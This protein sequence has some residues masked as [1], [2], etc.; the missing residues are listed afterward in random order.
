MAGPWQP[1]PSLAARRMFLLLVLLGFGLRMGYGLIRYRSAL[2]GSGSEFIG[3]WDHDALY[4]VLIAKAVLAGKGYVVDDSPIT[5]ERHLRYAGQDAL[6]KAPLYQY[7]LAGVFAVSGFSFKLFFPLQALLGGFSTGLTALI[8]LHVFGR[9]RAAWL[10]GG[11]AAVQPILVNSASQPYNENLFFFFFLASIWAFLVWLRSERIPWA[12]L[13]GLM[14]G[15]C[16]LTRESGE[17]LLVAMG[18]VVLVARPVTLRRCLGYGVV[19]A[20]TLAVV[21]PWTVRNYVRT[22]A[23]VP[24][25]SIVGV[26]FTEGNNECIAS[27]S[28]F[29]P[30]WSEGPC[31]LVD[32]Q[33]RAQMELLT[34]DAR[35]PA[36]VRADLASRRVALQ[37]VKDHPLIYARLVVRR[38]WTAL[39]PFNPRGNQRRTERIVLLLYWLAVFP[40]GIF[41]LIFGSTFGSTAGGK[42]NL[43]AFNQPGRMLLAV[44]MLLNLL[45][46]AAVLYWS[47]L[48]FLVGIYLL[49]GC[50]AGLA[51]DELLDRGR[52]RNGVTAQ[53][54]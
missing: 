38:L 12:A 41:G 36:C 51:Y 30:Y 49:L 44:L 40:A 11:A 2:K 32:Q 8:S 37:F 50:F 3:K 48:R 35:V 18:L 33:K 21:G 52:A 26:D 27:E 20:M 17:L 9:P 45:S 4:H 43:P 47:D 25:A 6:F 22:G 5:V 16:M 39:L 10:A 23:F 15:L 7:F 46:I 19:A 28:I 53:S 14:A 42:R 34:F 54:G 31:K 24:V 1:N 13:S 29:V